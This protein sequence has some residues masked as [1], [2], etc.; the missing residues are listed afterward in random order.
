[1]QLNRRLALGISILVMTPSISTAQRRGAFVEVDTIRARSALPRDT[2]PRFSN[3]GR[4]MVDPSG[5]SPFRASAWGAT[6]VAGSKGT[7]AL[8]QV[9]LS[10]SEKDAIGLTLASPLNSEGPT[11]IATLTGLSGTPRLAMNFSR[12][13]TQRS[14]LSPSVEAT[15]GAPLLTYRDQV[16]GVKLDRR[17]LNFSASVN[18]RYQHDRWQNTFVR[19]GLGAEESHKSRPPQSICSPIAGQPAGTVS[20]EDQVIGAPVSQTA[21]FADVELRTV[22][23]RG[24]GMAARVINDVEA[25]ESRVEVPLWFLPDDSG[26]LGGGVRLGY[27]TIDRRTTFTLFVSQFAP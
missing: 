10:G 9:N 17:K 13:V 11:D 24:L 22:L 3:L 19:V 18:L 16:G 4:L 27:S 14:G 5:R 2:T 6:I 25:G 23:H 8:F 21:K 1:M 26:K 15:A 20:C 7:E 12:N